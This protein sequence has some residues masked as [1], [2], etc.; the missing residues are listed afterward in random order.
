MFQELRSLL[1][2]KLN[3]QSTFQVTDECLNL[4]L[5]YL[6]SSIFLRLET[7]I[8]RK[9]GLITIKGTVE[10]KYAIAG[11]CMGQKILKL[12]SKLKE[13]YIPSRTSH[14]K[15]NMNI[16]MDINSWE[17]KAMQF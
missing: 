13:S 17:K 4:E 16:H 9:S 15:D 12:V 6:N 11:K 1:K 8:T 14:Q 5:H 7:G 3:L 2:A 10:Q